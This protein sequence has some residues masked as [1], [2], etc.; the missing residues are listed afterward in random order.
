MNK[1]LWLQ[2]SFSYNQSMPAWLCPVCKV[3]TVGTSLSEIKESP[4]KSVKAHRNSMFA[5][6]SED[7][8]F[9]YATRLWC[10]NGSCNEEVINSGRGEY[11]DQY[12]RHIISS[13][14]QGPRMRNFFPEYFFPH[15]QII[16]IPENTPDLIRQQINLSFP[17]YWIDR[18][19]CANKI[20][21]SVELIMDDLGVDSLDKR[22]NGDT[23][24]LSLHKRIELYSENSS[25]LG[26]LLLAVKWIG[27]EGSHQIDLTREDVLDGFEILEHTLDEL[28]S[29]RKQ[30]IAEK[31][32]EI[33]LRH[34]NRKIG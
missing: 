30:K 16:E 5:G 22:K 26:S 20:R 1:N 23:Y 4:S 7:A 14:F 11:W 17:I 25:E 12:G 15:L 29:D 19:A 21:V 9:K 13:A 24:N 10:S 2:E 3:G 27:N 8:V 32:A 6:Q 31:A 28:Y 33:N 18:S 34:Q